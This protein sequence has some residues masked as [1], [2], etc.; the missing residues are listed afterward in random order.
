MGNYSRY[1]DFGNPPGG[2]DNVV[3]TRE[4]TTNN[5]KLEVWKNGGVT[6][7]VA[8]GAIQLNK[9]QH[10]SVT[11]T[12]SGVATLFVNGNPVAT[13][14]SPGFIPSVVNRPNCYLGKSNNSSADALFQGK[15]S[16]FSFWSTALTPAQVQ[17]ASNATLNGSEA[18]LAYY[19][20]LGFN[21]PSVTPSITPPSPL[22]YSTATAQVFNET[23]VNSQSFNGS[24][25]FVN[26]APTA[27][28]PGV[29]NLT[30]GFS[31]SLW[32]Y[33]SAVGNYS[34]YF[35]FGNSPVFDNI[36]LTRQG[37]TNNLLLEVW[38]NGAATTLIAPGVIQPNTWQHFSVT[39]TS[40]GVATI[41]VNGAPVA[42]GTSPGFIPNVT[43]RPNCYLGKSNNGAD[44]L[45]QG[46]MSNF[47]FWN[48]SLTPAEV[49]ATSFTTYTGSEA[50]LVSYNPMGFSPPPASSAAQVIA[51]ANSSI[52]IP[53]N[54]LT[55]FSQ[56][57]SAGV[58]A[59]TSSVANWARY[60]DFGNGPGS[61]NILLTRVGT[62]NDLRFNVLRGGTEQSVTAPNAIQLNTWQHFSVTVTTAGVATLY[63][64]GAPVATNTNPGF[65]PNVVARAN[66]SIGKSNWSGDALFQGRM[67]G[68]SVWNT[69]LTP[70]QIATYANP[71]TPRLTGNEANLA[72]FVPMDGSP[73]ATVLDR[74]PRQLNGIPQGGV[75][76]LPTGSGY[77]T[78]YAGSL[79]L[80]GTS[81]FVQLPSAGLSDFSQG[82]SIGVW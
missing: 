20:P 68:L 42:T 64:N 41:Y 6:T 82:Y 55:D 36:D 60:F 21:P 78:P 77:N 49:Q 32:A 71:T 47:S 1:F 28:G 26:A 29:A 65:I 80:N 40:T 66:D 10:F 7:L 15:M 69:A 18:T 46:Q 48:K 37:T 16:N 53:G 56:G 30:N 2:G 22:P 81:S 59:Y 43:S 70:A 31:A 45:F 35:D 11:V 61:D 58:W 39:V 74:S 54:K 50:N 57:F 62:S 38:K 51:S 5:L 12:S 23:F 33:T 19:N 79:T 13:S 44:A 17:A 9:W 24:S 67:M 3:L 76:Y 63:V 72:V 4:G 8:P 25:T 73:A 27:S 34:R 75:A 52:S 14:T